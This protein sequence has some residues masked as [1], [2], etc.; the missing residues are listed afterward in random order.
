MK[1]VHGLDFIIVDYLQLMTVERM[2]SGANRV[3]QV[4]A[5]TAALKAL[6]KDLEVPVL[7]LA[8]LSREVEK[9][10]NK[11]PMLSDLRESGSIEQDADQVV[12]IYREDYYHAQ[13]E[14]DPESHDWGEWK[15]KADEI[16]GRAEIIFAKNR[17]GPTS[18]IP[19]RFEGA[20]TSFVE[21][22]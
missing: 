6:A 2:R 4:S 14:P 19:M 12:F 3:E 9:R 1:R 18:N 5:I 21:A 11:R 13:E 16:K 7:A 17:H 20:F 15:L 10:E 22:S 8:Q